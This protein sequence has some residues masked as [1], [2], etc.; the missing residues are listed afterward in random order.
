MS[1]ALVASSSVWQRQDAMKSW[2]GSA[3]PGASV[4]SQTTPPDE[5]RTLDFEVKMK[6]SVARAPSP[7]SS[8]RGEGAQTHRFDL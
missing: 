5:R 7:P 1:V 8:E 4:S 6:K 2:L 3:S